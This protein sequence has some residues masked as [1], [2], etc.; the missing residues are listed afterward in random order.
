MATLASIA[1]RYRLDVIVLFGSRA[2][3][4]SPP[5]SDAD[6]CVIAPRF[7][8]NEI[9][10]ANDLTRAMGAPVDLVLFHR[11]DPVLKFYAVVPGKRLYG[12]AR[13]FARARL[14][15]VKAWQDCRKIDEARKISLERRL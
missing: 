1:R 14:S 2:Q 15:A 7:R 8:R 3:G 12:S 5:D 9:D 6:I 10:L 11:A 4:R 13:E